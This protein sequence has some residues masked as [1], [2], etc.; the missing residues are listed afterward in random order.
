MKKY[1]ILA[2]L[3]SLAGTALSQISHSFS[4]QT[5]DFSISTDNEYTLVSNNNFNASTIQEGAPGLPV[6]IKSK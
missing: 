3:L 6:L 4:F 2:V 5:A 1:F